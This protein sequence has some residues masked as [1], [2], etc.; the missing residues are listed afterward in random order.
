MSTCQFDWMTLSIAAKRI[1]CRQARG[2]SNK[3]K[4]KKQHLAIKKAWLPA[5][6]ALDFSIAPLKPRQ[7]IPGDRMSHLHS[8][9]GR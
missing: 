5:P 8:R 2:R 9:G 7:I 4:N 1:E 3:G 6:H